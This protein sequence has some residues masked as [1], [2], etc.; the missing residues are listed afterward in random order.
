MCVCERG[1]AKIEVRH[2]VRPAHLGTL[3][4]TQKQYQA[5]MVQAHHLRSYMQQDI[6]HPSHAFRSSLS[7]LSD[8]S[9]SLIAKSVRTC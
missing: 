6:S 1:K 3:C 5:P 8:L 7:A 2:D 4:Q 9:E